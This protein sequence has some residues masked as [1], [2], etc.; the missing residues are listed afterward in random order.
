MACLW[1]ACGD[2]FL[3]KTPETAISTGDFFKSAEDFRIYVNNFYNDKNLLSGGVF[4]DGST[5]NEVYSSGY[6][7]IYTIMLGNL[8]PQNAT[9][10]ND[11]ASLRSINVM[12]SNL[13]NAGSVTAAEFNNYVGIAHYFRAWFYF[14]KIK[15]YSD[16]PWINRPLES[17]APELYNAQDSRAL[18]VDSVMADLEFAAANIS[19][20]MGNKTRVHKYCAL[21]LLSRFALFEGTYR[22]YHPELNLAT[23]ADRF[24]QRAASA[25][26]EIINSK[27]FELSGNGSTPISPGIVGCAGFRAVFSSL[28]LNGNKE[29]IQ[30]CAYSQAQGMSNDATGMMHSTY[31]GN[32]S[33]SRSLMESFLTDDGKPFS[34]VPDYDK[35]EF[36]DIFA[37]RDPRLAETF[38]YPGVHM[39]DPDRYT[40]VQPSN[41]GYDQVKF[42]GETSA[43]ASGDNGYVGLPLY[44]YGEVLL[45][46]AEA[47]A[48]LG[49]LAAA[50]V[51]KS[52]NLLRDRAGMPHFD[53]NRETD[54]ILKD[55]YPGVSDVNILAVRRERRVEL[56]GEGLRDQDIRRWY[57]GKLMEAPTTQEGIYVPSLPYFYDGNGDGPGGITGV[58]AKQSDLA[59]LP[60]AQQDYPDVWYYLED[61]NLYLDKGT[62]GHI[63]VNGDKERNFVEPKYYYRPIPITHTVL[64]P[65]L[66]QPFGW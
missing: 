61:R 51:A 18:V 17:T 19:A 55:Q 65:N 15:N 32:Y 64:N 42:F 22:K 29:V 40:S 24:L 5:D 52:I 58:L 66:K 31:H 45:N 26:E 9:G 2:D 44:R 14:N 38:A 49:T 12:L 30:W 1:T 20:D 43:K 48:E 59:S 36:K 60:Q 46:Y 39:V 23:T 62:S 50:D 41:G 8:S 33:L 13:Q 37:N 35:K 4:R 3:Q 53:A 57:A 54:Q 56:A 34:S 47:K 63:R 25:A 6:P 28:D 11:W 16:V 27:V 10:W 7:E 21:A